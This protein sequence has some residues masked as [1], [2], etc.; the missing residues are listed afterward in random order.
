VLSFA[1]GLA[2]V[3][4]QGRLIT[5]EATVMASLGHFDPGPDRLW[6][7]VKEGLGWLSAGL[8]HLRAVPEE[9]EREKRGPRVWVGQLGQEEEG[10]CGLS[11]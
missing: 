11:W 1:G 8:A 5:G 10:R 2:A 7:E 4:L 6:E 9:G 3:E